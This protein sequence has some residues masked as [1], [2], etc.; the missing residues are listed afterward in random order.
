MTV[1]LQ[2]LQEGVIIERKREGE[3]AIIKVENTKKKYLNTLDT[4]GLNHYI[5]SLQRLC[6]LTLSQ[7]V[8][9][10]IINKLKGHEHTHTIC[11]TL[12]KGLE[13]QR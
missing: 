10:N 1:E 4:F 8:Q 2:Q 12:T 13:A 5:Q 11:D 6:T 7:S 3:R 9:E